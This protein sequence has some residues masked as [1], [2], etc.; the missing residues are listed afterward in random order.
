MATTA[1]RVFVVWKPEAGFGLG[2]IV[3]LV[4]S[5]CSIRVLNAPPVLKEPTAQTSLAEVA[6]TA[7]S[8]ADPVL[9][10]GL[11]TQ[12]VQ[13]RWPAAAGGAVARAESS[14]VAAAVTPVAVRAIHGMPAPSPGS[15]SAGLLRCQTMLGLYCPIWLRRSQQAGCGCGTQSVPD[16]GDCNTPPNGINAAGF[17]PFGWPEGLRCERGNGR[18]P[19]AP[20]APCNRS[21]QPSDTPGGVPHQGAPR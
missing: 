16:L 2:T 8:V 21:P 20:G 3:H 17:P 18:W 1:P 10:L 14:K 11:T 15:G 7:L 6:A 19:A 9:G 13:A 5:Q 4:P 12:P